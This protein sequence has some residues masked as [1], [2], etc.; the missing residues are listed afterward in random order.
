MTIGFP[1]ERTT[2]TGT[3]S[4]ATE[5]MIEAAEIVVGP[6]VVGPVV[7]GVGMSSKATSTEV[8]ALVDEA[9]SANG[10]SRTDVVAVATRERFRD[11]ARLRLG[12]RVVGVSDDTLIAA[13]GPTE[14]TIGIGARVADT[15]ALLIAGDH[16]DLVSP[17]LRSAH[18][19]V[20]IAAAP[21]TVP[22]AGA[23]GGDGHRIAE[24]LGI[25]GSQ[26]VDLSASMNPFAPDV[27]PLISSV[28]SRVGSP[29]LTTYPDPAAA[30]IALATAI[31]V[32]PRRLV[33]TNG[34]A[35]AIALVAGLI[36]IGHV[37]DPEFSLYGR[38]LER[39]D[40]AAPRWRS[41]PS[42][43]LGRLASDDEVAAV[44]DEAFYP[45]ATGA[46]TRGDDAAWRL[47][48]LTKLWNCPGLRLGYVIAPDV[49]GAEAVRLRQPQWAVNGL[50][51]AVLP[52]LIGQTD[53]VTWTT[54]IRSLRTEFSAGLIA[55][56][57]DV[58]DTDVNWLLVR[59]EGLR[60]SLARVGVV[61]RDCASFGLPATHR[62]ALPRPE[63]LIDVIEA[64]AAVAN[65]H[66]H[67]RYQP[68]PQTEPQKA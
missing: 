6:V 26:I 46:W 60:A 25:D 4:G 45:L 19:T 33:L 37:V 53:L 48:S 66:R 24:S 8:A 65:R 7:V 63:Q 20:A 10:C 38:H 47:G 61:V 64:F 44:W 39:L 27:G 57:F 18:A 9:L 58:A 56:G 21:P 50:A 14:R 62:V 32:D 1:T 68:Q 51:L 41:N 30:T 59:H 31:G 36:P 17:M 42:N 52:T 13:S 34:G 2:G 28:L 55:L 29:A 11:D 5:I 54:R 49:A 67:Q 15:A 23:H 43:P 3:P 12:A 22:P 40:P 35:E 16:S